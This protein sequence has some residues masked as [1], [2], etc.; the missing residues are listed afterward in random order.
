[1]VS[2]KSFIG[3]FEHMVLAAVMRLGEEA[4]GGSIIKEIQQ[5]TGR[6]VPSGSVSITLDRLESKGYLTSHMGS[7]QARRGGRPKRFVTVTKT[8]LLA[9]KDARAAM[10]NLWNGLERKLEEA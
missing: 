7:P 3:E 9:V 6:R 2:K 1:M 4:Y 8:G 5:E 10:L